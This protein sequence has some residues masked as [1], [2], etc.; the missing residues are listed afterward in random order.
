MRGATAGN[1][2]AYSIIKIQSKV[3]LLKLAVSCV[4]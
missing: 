4:D 3:T 1:M 2:M